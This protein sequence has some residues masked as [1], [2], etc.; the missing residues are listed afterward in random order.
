MQSK[1]GLRFWVYNLISSEFLFKTI[2]PVKVPNFSVYL[3]K[4]DENKSSALMDWF[5]I[6][7]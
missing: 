1:N 4:K 5:E 2:K 3:T 6:K 7:F